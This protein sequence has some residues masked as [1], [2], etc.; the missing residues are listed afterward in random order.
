MLFVKAVK[1]ED[2][3]FV[4]TKTGDDGKESSVF[5]G[6]AAWGL[7]TRYQ[8]EAAKALD[9]GVLGQWILQKNSDES[10]LM[11]TVSPYNNRN[12]LSVRIYA[13]GQP[14]RQGVTMGA[15]NFVYLRGFLTTSPEYVLGREAY[16]S[17]LYEQVHEQHKKRCEGCR[18]DCGGQR[19]HTCLQPISHAVELLNGTG[20]DPFDFQLTLAKRAS[21]RK[22]FL[23]HPHTIYKMLHYHHRAEIER[24]IAAELVCA[25][26]DDTIGSSGDS[27]GDG[28]NTLSMAV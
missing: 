7:L 19:D 21:D 27:G 23:A 5:V 3:G 14:T 10:T 13:N 2:G 11:L 8:V 17:L 1:S 6:I 22:V 4:I 24:E 28:E 9:A 25:I 20:V 12:L 16:K 15:A 26:P 18:L